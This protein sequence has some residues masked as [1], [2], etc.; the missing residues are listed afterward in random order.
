MRGRYPSGEAG[1]ADPGRLNP[2]ARR[3]GRDHEP[4]TIDLAQAGRFRA[5]GKEEWESGTQDLR[6]ADDPV[7]DETQAEPVAGF[8]IVVAGP[9]RGSFVTVHPGMNAVGR[10]PSQQIR[11]D[12]G[13]EGIS[14]ENHCQ[15]IYDSETH[16][17]FVQRGPDARPTWLGQRPVLAPVELQAGDELRLG[18][19]V[20][21][22][23]P[24][25]SDDFDWE[26]PEK[27]HGSMGG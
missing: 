26:R 24:L 25:C 8:L 21:R 6:A 2:L 19:T 14:S 17:F 18:E 4:A 16:K 1:G 13:D 9:G 10:A 5:S 3:F 15:V 20:L 12:H 11:L 7:R 22:F 27:H 23:L